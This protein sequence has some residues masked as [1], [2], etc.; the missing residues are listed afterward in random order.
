[1]KWVRRLCITAACLFLIFLLLSRARAEGP[2]YPCETDRFGAGL[3]PKF[4]AITD[5]DVASLHIGWYSDWTVKLNPPRPNGVEYAQLIWVTDGTFT[6]SLGQL[7]P[8]VDA[9]PGSLWMIGNEPE[10]IWQGNNTPEQYAQV[11]HQLYEVIKGRDPTAQLAIGGVV[12][13]TPLRLVWLDRVLAHYQATYGRPMQVDVWNIHIQILQELRDSWG[14]EIPRGLPDESGRLYGVQDN[15]NIQVFQQLIG[16]F[17]TWMRD[18]GE[19]DKPLIISEY[20]I[21]MPVQYGFTPER[22]NAFMDASF[23]YLLAAQDAS[24]G[25][26]ADENRL[27]QRW[28][29]YS[30][31]EQPYDLLTG[32]GFNGPL[33]DYRYPQYPGV[34]TAHGVNFKAY[35]DALLEDTV[36]LQQGASGYT[37][38]ED[39]YIY[40]YEPDTIRCGENALRV[41][42]KQHYA[43]LLGFDLSSIPANSVV[44]EATLEVYAKGWGG[45]DMTVDAYRIL[46]DVSMCQATWNQAASGNAWGVAGCNDTVTDRA[47]A[48]ESSVS[49]SG[50]NKWYSF[51]VTV[52]V[53]QWVNGSVANNGVLLRGASAVSTGEFY[54]I[55][56]EDALV[57]QRPKLVIT[58]LGGGRSSSYYTATGASFAVQARREMRI[59]HYV[60]D[61]RSI[62]RNLLRE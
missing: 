40:R 42:Y 32:Q 47:A 34:I 44:A 54:W 61:G 15:D 27:V 31:N 59:D 6:P 7:G 26:P 56:A 11:Y 53:Q 17:R 45:S 33:F 5:Y 3:Q 2:L 1:M 43:A 21:L 19:R 13:P 41:G 38:A 18:R 4:G 10:C 30:L 28:L 46:R 8:M 29:W 9:N 14:A 58:Y 12:E 60:L 25:C 20:G 51:D 16:E 48:P 37:G 36:T 62:R 23:D 52:L 39:T 24:L 49:T 50:I 22:V 57:N 55:S 35:T